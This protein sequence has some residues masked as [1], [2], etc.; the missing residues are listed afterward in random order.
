MQ[1]SSDANKLVTYSYIY[2]NFVGVVYFVTEVPI[3]ASRRL[4]IS[5]PEIIR[6]SIEIVKKAFN[7][8]SFFQDCWMWMTFTR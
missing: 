6:K 5:F 1:V 8:F 7:L 4:K 3:N 2:R